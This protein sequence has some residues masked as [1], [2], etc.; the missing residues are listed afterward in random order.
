[1]SKAMGQTATPADHL[2]ADL[3]SLKNMG[4]LSLSKEEKN[5]MN[6]EIGKFALSVMS[7]ISKGNIDPQRIADAR[8]ILSSL[9]RSGFGM[10]NQFLK[11]MDK[12]LEK[13]GL[14]KEKTQIP[15]RRE[16]KQNQREEDI[17][18]KRQKTRPLMLIG[19]G[20]R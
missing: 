5:A 6:K 19:R 3:A 10:A 2:L 1:M 18:K 15:R 7:S 9:S 4:G 8:R 17:M 13:A 20:G 12:R 14:K 11:V 16:Q